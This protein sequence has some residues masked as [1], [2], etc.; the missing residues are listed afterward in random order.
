MLIPVIYPNGRHDMVKDFMLSRMIEEMEISQF[1]RKEGWVNIKTDPVRRKRSLIYSGPERR[2]L[3]A[4]R[5]SEMSEI[6]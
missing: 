2:E 4:L 3:E 1:K 5:I 6:I